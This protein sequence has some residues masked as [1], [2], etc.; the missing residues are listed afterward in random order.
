MNSKTLLICIGL[1]LVPAF[2]LATIT[3]G[4][5]AIYDNDQSQTMGISNLDDT[6]FVICYSDGGSSGS[7][8]CRVGTRSGTSTSYGS[9]FT[10]TGANIYNIKVRNLSATEFIIAFRNNSGGAKVRMGTVN[11]NSI[12]YSSSKSVT[13]VYVD[14][15]GLT[16]LSATKFAVA[17]KDNN[18]SGR[19]AVRIGTV[20]GGTITLGSI[21]YFN[22]GQTNH[23]SIDA[24]DSGTIAISYKDDSNSNKGTSI[25]GSVSGTVVNY[26]N[27]KVFNTGNTEWINTIAL[28]NTSFVVVYSDLNNGNAGTAAVG[29]IN[30]SNNI[31][32]GSEYV[33]NNANTTN[34]VATGHGSSN[35]TMSFSDG[36]SGNHLNANVGT[37]S[38][39]SISYG[40]EVMLNGNVQV[41]ATAAIGL[42][43]FVTIYKDDPNG[44][45]STAVAAYVAGILPVELLYFN[46]QAKKKA[47]DLTWETASELNNRGFIIQKSFD[48]KD[49]QDLDFVEG[50]GSSSNRHM[51]SWRDEN[52]ES[53]MN[54]YRLVQEDF[55][56]A[57][58]FTSI[59]SI[60]WDN[61]GPVVCVFPNPVR[62]NC[63]IMIEGDYPL[64]LKLYD[65]TGRYI[66]A[67]NNYETDI[68][69]EHLEP[70]LYLLVINFLNRT[71]QVSVLKQ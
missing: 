46:V 66:R 55:D 16:A 67:Y 34:L 3:T 52:P 4:S 59:E 50:A 42:D 43:Y 9:P 21:Y 30:S 2:L 1:F 39:T 15:F 17:Y 38:G 5:E 6:K 7:G 58:T 61:N 57:K 48:G 41:P 47:I 49:W 13:S 11:G 36:G 19:G 33:F 35:F 53:G 18:S 44:G 20:S 14:N 27:E 60:D 31:T 63:N 64:S 62:A 65:S 40:N 23:I 54:Y 32:F 51:Y 45:K 8:T 37:I 22:S 10:F 29:N 28:T 24:L 69:L 56:G 70:G 68:D 25:I 71:E 12:S 26:F